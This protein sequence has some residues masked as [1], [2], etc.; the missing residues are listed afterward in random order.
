VFDTIDVSRKAQNL[1]RN[2]AIAFVI[3]G[4][5]EGDERTVQYEGTADEP[6][7]AEPERIS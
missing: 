1:R 7:G 6:A 2:R 5:K 3:G 4:T